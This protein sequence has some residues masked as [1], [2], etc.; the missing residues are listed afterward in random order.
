MASSRILYAPVPLDIEFKSPIYFIERALSIIERHQNHGQHQY[1]TQ[2]HPHGQ[3]SEWWKN[4]AVDRGCGRQTVYPQGFQTDTSREI[5]DR[6]RFF[7]SVDFVDTQ[8]KEECSTGMRCHS[9]RHGK[10]DTEALAMAAPAVGPG[11]ITW[12]IISGLR[13][14]IRRIPVDYQ[15]SSSLQT[16]FVEIRLANDERITTIFEDIL[17]RGAKV[18]P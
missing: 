15:V 1:A 17:Q 9:S 4:A 14:A 3:D 11:R 7:Q 2:G 18:E 5:R 8:V 6:R 16:G 10:P 12:P 13:P